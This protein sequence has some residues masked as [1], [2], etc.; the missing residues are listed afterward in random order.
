MDY[1][2]GIDAG[3]VQLLAAKEEACHVFWGRLLVVSE[4][5]LKRGVSLDQIHSQ[6]DQG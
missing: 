2:L 5:L 1:L 3:I 6:H 4:N